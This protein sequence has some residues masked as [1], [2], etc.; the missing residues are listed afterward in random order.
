MEAATK[1]VA[2]GVKHFRII[3]PDVLQ[4]HNLSAMAPT[5]RSAVG[6]PKAL[7]LANQLKRFNPNCRVSISTRHAHKPKG[8]D[9]LRQPCD[10]FVSCVDNDAARMATAI[11]ARQSLTPHL[12]IATSIQRVSK[13]L[14]FTGDTRLFLPGQGCLRCVEGESITQDTID[15]VH[16]QGRYLS[17]QSPLHWNGQR[18]GS[19]PTL[20]AMTAG[21]G[22][23][24]WLDFISGTLR[25]AFWQRIFWLP[26]RGIEPH[27]VAMLGGSNCRLCSE[28]MWVL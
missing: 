20:N 28:A 27:A 18:A 12:D 21:A 23:Q 11:V 22:I 25:E 16:F 1:L 19:L 9:F 15:E 6:Q 24:I 10:L 3:D 8:L 13:E 2:C 4:D 14:Q 7:V 17:N 26:G 5:P